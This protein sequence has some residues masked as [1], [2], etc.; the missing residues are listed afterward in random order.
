MHRCLEVLDILLNVFD[1]V[2]ADEQDGVCQLS[3]VSRTCRTFQAPALD[4]LWRSLPNLVPLVKSLPASVLEEENVKDRD[5]G[6]GKLQ[7]VRYSSSLS[8]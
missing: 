8:Y 1:Y 7:L 3:L 5:G 4:I 6:I 2:Y